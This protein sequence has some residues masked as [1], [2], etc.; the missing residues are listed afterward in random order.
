MATFRAVAEGVAVIGII[1]ALA[2]AGWGFKDVDAAV[3]KLIESGK[4]S[5]NKGS[6]DSPVKIVGGSM[7]FFAL[8]W[9]PV[10][11]GYST[12]VNDAS[13][14]DVEGV[15]TGPWVRKISAPWQVELDARQADGTNVNGSGT[16]VFVCSQGVPNLK[17]GCNIS[18]AMQS[19]TIYVG[20]MDPGSTPVGVGFLGPFKPLAPFDSP[21]QLLRYRDPTSACYFCELIWQVIIKYESADGTNTYTVKLECPDGE[22]RVYIG[23]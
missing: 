18:P 17:T 16:G 1:G 9:A 10:T 4:S 3:K 23:Q 12:P 14:I 22:C 15:P 21:S 19:T 7:S 11:G 13:E 6:G 2:L 20:P 5:S 8:Q